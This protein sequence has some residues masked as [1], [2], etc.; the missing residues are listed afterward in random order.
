MILGVARLVFNQ[1]YLSRLSSTAI[2]LAMMLT[3]AAQM[4]SLTACFL[5]TCLPFGFALAFTCSL[6]GF[7]VAFLCVVIIT[8]FLRE[9]TPRPVLRAW[10]QPFG[11]L[12]SPELYLDF[13]RTRGASMTERAT[14]LA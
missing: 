12:S 9:A 3:M 6:L 10:G 13:Q 7:L 8:S 4:L 11:R 14:V 1:D 5:A 2:K